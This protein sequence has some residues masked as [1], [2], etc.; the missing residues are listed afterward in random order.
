MK[1]SQGIF[2]RE[3]SASP[4]QLLA[5]V[6]D[7]SLRRVEPLPPATVRLL[8]KRQMDRLEENIRF[9]RKKQEELNR[10]MDDY[11]RNLETLIGGLGRAVGGADPAEPKAKPSAK[12]SPPPAASQGGTQVRCMTCGEEK[13]FQDLRVI[14][15][16]PITGP[17]ADPP[18]LIVVDAT[19]DLK[20][21]VFSCPAC[22]D[23][24][25][26]IRKLA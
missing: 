19:G 15:A 20:K 21:G 17:Q 22:G 26:L 11:V 7:P 1:P 25:L 8:R 12:A 24:N 10:K 16:R 4:A 5:E 6:G 9:L 18:E 14:V 2:F 23:R 3:S 13:L